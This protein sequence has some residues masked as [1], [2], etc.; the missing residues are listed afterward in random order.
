MK[1]VRVVPL[2]FWHNSKTGQTASIFSLP[3]SDDYEIV[4]RGYTWR[5][6]EGDG[7]QRTGLGRK[8]APDRETALVIAQQLIGYELIKE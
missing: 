5:I 8:I 6:T 4:E 3:P 7:S 1:T 2:R